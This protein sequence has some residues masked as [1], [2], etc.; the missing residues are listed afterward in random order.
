MDNG[1]PNLSSTTRVVVKV[2]DV[3]D[4][5]PEFDQK[6]YA[7]RMPSNAVIDQKLFQVRNVLK[8]LSFTLA[9]CVLL[10]KLTV[11]LFSST[12]KSY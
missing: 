2:D 9:L 11:D 12:C 8:F 1:E 6:S 10:C 5:A 7:V 3:N 4:N